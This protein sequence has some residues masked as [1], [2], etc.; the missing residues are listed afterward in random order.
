MSAGEYPCSI[1]KKNFDVSSEGPSFGVR[2]TKGLR[3]KRRNSFYFQVVASLPTKACSFYWHYLHWQ[4]QFKFNFTL[5]LWISPLSPRNHVVLWKPSSCLD[6]CRA[7]RNRKQIKFYTKQ[8][9]L[10]IA[11]VLSWCAIVKPSAFHL[12]DP[13]FSLRTNER[14][15]QRS[16]Q[17]TPT[18]NMN[19]VGKE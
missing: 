12:W 5:F 8:L 3:S 2:S 15:S 19:R 10:H 4:R 13:G 14:V 11:T 1:Y 7:D 16:T 9:S 17:F 18:G 6:C